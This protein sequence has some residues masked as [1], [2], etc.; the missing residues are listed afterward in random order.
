MSALKKKRRCQPCQE[1]TDQNQ[2]PG[3]SLPSLGTQASHMCHG[4][5]FAVFDADLRVWDSHRES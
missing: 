5:P 2:P 1:F 3:A 4:V